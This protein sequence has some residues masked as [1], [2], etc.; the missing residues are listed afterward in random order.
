MTYEDY[1]LPTTDNPSL[2][3]YSP[4]TE[5]AEDRYVDED[6]WVT[7]PDDIDVFSTQSSDPDM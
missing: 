2:A 7:Q 5:F 1:P 4:E 3:P 6:D